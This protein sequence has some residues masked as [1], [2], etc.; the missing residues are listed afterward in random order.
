MR[1]IA[2]LVISLLSSVCLHAQNFEDLD[3]SFDEARKELDQARKEFADSAD[4]ALT[5]YLDY[6]AKLFEE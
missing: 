6:E 1:R 4:A 3:I 5:A 2:L